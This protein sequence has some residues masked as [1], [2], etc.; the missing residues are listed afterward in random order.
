MP[1]LCSCIV[2]VTNFHLICMLH[3]LLV[4]AVLADLSFQFSNF[5]S[6]VLIQAHR[7]KA[8]QFDLSILMSPLTALRHKHNNKKIAILIY[9]FLPKALAMIRR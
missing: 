6:P 9:Y 2:S 7:N 5:I 8:C 1:Y 3:I 4:V